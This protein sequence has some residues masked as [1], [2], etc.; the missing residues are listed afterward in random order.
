MKIILVILFSIAIGSKLSY[1]RLIYTA[2]LKEAKSLEENFSDLLDMALIKIEQ[3]KF[4]EHDFRTLMFLTNKLDKLRREKKDDLTVYW[5]SRQ[6][7]R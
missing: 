3:N 4:S 7:K 6:G 5:Y 1:S 2:R